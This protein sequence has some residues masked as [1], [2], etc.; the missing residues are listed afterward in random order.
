MISCG[1][2]SPSHLVTGV[3]LLWVALYFFGKAVLLFKSTKKVKGGVE[4]G[5]KG[6]LD[7]S[8]RGFQSQLGVDVGGL[9]SAA[10]L[11]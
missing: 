2:W 8:S 7:I 5:I 4:V 6:D 1:H 9:N 3:V 11:G 10:A